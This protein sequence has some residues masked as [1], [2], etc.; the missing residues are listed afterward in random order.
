MPQK[1]K[2]ILSIIV[3][4]YNSQSFL[5]QCIDSI[6]AQTFENYEIILINDGSTDDSGA[7]CDEY[8]SN[9]P[10]KIH[11]RHKANGGAAS[12]RNA[13]IEMA[14]GEFIGFID[15]DDYIHPEMFSFL[16]SEIEKNGADIIETRFIKK[17]SENDSTSEGVLISG[18]DAFIEMLNWR[19]TTSL[20]TKLFRRY[21]LDGLKLDEGHTNEDFRY[22]C[23]IL[24]KDILV[25]NTNRAFYNYR[26][27]PGSVTRT[28]RPNFF[29]IFRNL[30]YVKSIICADDSELLRHFNRYCLTMHI[31]SGV[32]IVRGRHNNNYKAW[33]RKNRSFI[34]R[35]WKIWL[36]DPNLSMRWRLKAIYTFL[37]L[38]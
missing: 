11:T 27:T 28:L 2:P 21:V 26:E 1:N 33:L 9:F 37:H 22:L 5:R 31:M 14:Q 15:S 18:R 32:R 13:G 17:G 19:L 25:F 3:P 6:L 30:D 23:E 20:C 24:Q 12:A 38:P 29:D 8:S 35:N 36:A 10:E 4:V 7:I 34:L 16:V